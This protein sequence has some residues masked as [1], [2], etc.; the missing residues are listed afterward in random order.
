[1]QNEVSIGSLMRTYGENYISKHKLKGQTKGIVRLLGSCRT[2]ALG[3]HYQKC[4]SCN[5]IS[6]SY[7]SCR[8]RHCPSCQQKD[9]EQWLDNRTKEL[10]PV[11]YYHVVFTLPHDLNPLCMRNKKIMYDIL[12]RSASQT[13]LE[14]AKDPTHMGADTGLL[15]VLHSWGQNMMQHPHLHVIMPC[16]GL[17]FDR[18]HWVDIEKN[19]N[20]FVHYKSLSNKFRGKFLYYLRQSYNSG[21]LVLSSKELRWLSVKKSFNTFVDK[22]YKKSWVVN[23]QKPIGK[24]SKVV[25]YLSRYVFRTAITNGRIKEVRDGRVYFTWKN[26]HNGQFKIMSLEV[27]EFINRFLLH[28]LPKGFFKVRYYGIFSNRCRK[29]NIEIA[30]SHI[31]QQ[32]IDADQ[33][34][35]EDG[36][37]TWKKHDHVWKH[38]LEMITK[39]KRPNC[40]RCKKG[41]MHFA[42]IVPDEPLKPG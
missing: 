33:E 10:L 9:K 29:H 15:A 12:F 18:T 13:L 21:N 36:C 41:H 23:I 22:L 8:N 40:P 35:H 34:A 37:L 4:D 32:C 1:M 26:Y 11:G 6:K 3:R 27:D 7:N 38:L 2:Q 20:F 17:S 5:Y 39:Y 25:E 30:K 31:E 16:G 42:G 24:P 19:D 14:L 28:T